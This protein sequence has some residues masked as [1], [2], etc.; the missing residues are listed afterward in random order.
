LMVPFGFVPDIIRALGVCAGKHYKAELA[1]RVLI[2]LVKIINLIFVRQILSTTAPVEL[3][4]MINYTIWDEFED[5]C[6]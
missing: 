2:F 3:F 5:F 1:A 4:L 6:V